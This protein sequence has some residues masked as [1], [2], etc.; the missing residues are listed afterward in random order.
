MHTDLQRFWFWWR[1]EQVGSV[2]FLETIG[3]DVATGCA[4]DD[5]IFCLLPTVRKH[6]HIS[7]ST[8]D[9]PKQG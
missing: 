2:V 6:T 9:P 4:S 1:A 7:L 8:S 3:L 5:A